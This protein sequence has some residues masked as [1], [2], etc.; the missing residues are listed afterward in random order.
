MKAENVTPK[1]KKKTRGREMLIATVILAV[2]AVVLLIV[3][4]SRGQGQHLEGLRMGGV[5]TLEVI[6]ILVC[7]FVVAGM[8]QVLIPQEVI[9]QWVGAESGIRGIFLGSIAGGLTPGGPFVS[10]PVV[11][12]LHRAG[13]SVGTVVAYITGWSLYAVMRV[14]MEVGV[15][16]VRLTVIRFLSTLIFPPLAG[17]I[18]QA[19]FARWV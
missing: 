1:P 3:G 16:G 4:Y 15:L 11:A 9:A 8:A 12:G 6:P 18:A 19:L 7:A 5:M 17:L 10:L 14:P 13:A 2:M